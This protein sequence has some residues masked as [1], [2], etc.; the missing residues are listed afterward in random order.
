MFRAQVVA[1]SVNPQG[2][3]LVT[4]RVEMPKYLQQELNTHKIL[5]K[6]AASS[7]ATP[8]SATLAKLRGA[9]ATAKSPAIEAD[10]F[11]PLRFEQN[12][13]GMQSSIPCD[14]DT[15]RAAREQYLSAM[16]DACRHAD[17]LQS[18]GIHKQFINR[19][20]EPYCWT[21][22]VITG[23]E[24]ANF[25]ALRTHED[26]EPHFRHL[27][28]IMYV[29]YSLSKPALVKWGEWHLPFVSEAEKARAL[30]EEAGF[31]LADEETVVSP[32]EYLCRLSA[33]RC[34][35]VSYAMLERLQRPTV[36]D[37]LDL[38]K[39]LVHRTPKHMGPTEHQAMAAIPVVF[40]GK[41][42]LR[43]NLIDWVQFRKTIP[44]ECIKG[45]VADGD[46]VASWQ[47]PELE[48]ALAPWGDES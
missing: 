28:R 44:G 29:A 32:G 37:D 5:N 42:H 11:I 45:F 1:H 36:D 40:Q 4:F 18:L 8:V 48:S 41:P 35:R 17:E 24:W 33:A 6:S 34:A 27:A 47:I 9:A 7:R 10:P 43:S 16:T 2:K 38:Y 31:Y 23:T 30:A 19:V 3:E 25:F 15:E 46:M 20:V 39:R 22:C 26:A 14:A 13:P 21:R 12:A